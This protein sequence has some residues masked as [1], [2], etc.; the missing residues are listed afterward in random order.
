M[1]QFIYVVDGIEFA[2]TEAFGKA[3]K[4]AKEAAANAHTVIERYVV[5]GENIRHEIYFK[6]GVFNSTK[7]ATKENVYI[8]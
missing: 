6:G 1:K 2:D 4:M 5:S 3:W 7:Y 8:F